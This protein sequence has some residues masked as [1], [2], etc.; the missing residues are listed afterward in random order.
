MVAKAIKTRKKK[1]VIL[2]YIVEICKTMW[3]ER[4]FGLFLSSLWQKAQLGY[5][6]EQW[7][8]GLNHVWG[9]HDKEEASPTLDNSKCVKPLVMPFV[10]SVEKHSED[11][12]PR[13]WST[14]SS[15]SVVEAY[16]RTE[17]RSKG[18]RKGLTQPFI[19][20]IENKTSKSKGCKLNTN[21]VNYC[22]TYWVWTLTTLWWLVQ[23][24]GLY[25]GFPM[26]FHDP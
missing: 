24:H 3:N 10:A 20:S 6:A 14:D 21:I 23:T 16:I 19:A 4:T 17:R 12:K 8:L 1:P 9:G 25:R 2:I 22:I 18:V 11:Y 7:I 5:F 13:W 15:N 26:G